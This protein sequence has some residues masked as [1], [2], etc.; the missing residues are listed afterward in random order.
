MGR[1]RLPEGTC[2]LCKHPQIAAM[3]ADSLAGLSDAEVAAR[4]TVAGRSWRL[5]K[6]H[7]LNLKPTP[8]S[9][10]SFSASEMPKLDDPGLSSV[11]VKILSMFFLRKS[12]QQLAELAEETRSF[13]AHVALGEQIER[14]DRLSKGVRYAPA[15]TDSPTVE[16]TPQP[17]T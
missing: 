3:E 6:A 7:S 2:G 15:L 12:V 4:Y 14:I 9:A 5:H 16:I 17:T 1:P 13:K 11:E 8:T 10:R